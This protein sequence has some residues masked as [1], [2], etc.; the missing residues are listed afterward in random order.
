[1]QF[2]PKNKTSNIILLI[3]SFVIVSLILWNTNSFFQKI[4]GGRTPQDG[5]LG[6]GP[7]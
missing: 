1:M 6:Y 7:F 4:Q 2:N 5:N 3:A